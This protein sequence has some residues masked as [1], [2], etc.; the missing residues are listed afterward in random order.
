M[1]LK[2][3]F[4]GI[5]LGIGF[6][7]PG[8]S[9][10]VLAAILGI[11][12]TIIYR[13]N[14]LFK[15]FKENIYY[16]TPLILGV[17][18]GVL[19]FS[20][21]ILY[22]LNNKLNFISYVF[23]GLILGCVPYL[24]QEIKIKV[25]KNIAIIPFLIAIL[26]GIVLYLIENNSMEVNNNPNFITMFI[27]GSLYA[28]GK[29]VPGISGSALLM[30]IGVYKY[31]L[32]VVANPFAITFNIILNFIPFVIS[33]IISSIIILKLIDYL[34]NNYFRLTYSAIIGFV[35]SSILF[36]YPGYFSFIS[37]VIATMSFLISYTLSK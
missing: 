14:N 3:F 24:F 7:I 11:Y 27:A 17:I 13:L 21:L 36:I 26:F 31:F 1:Y 8:V 19:F 9:G 34:L 28:V 5:V 6:I 32:S 2:N 29:L 33:F 16:L 4:F 12:D 22:L 15:N 23:I 35:I 25:N 30:L 18:I 37:L 10:G 20:K